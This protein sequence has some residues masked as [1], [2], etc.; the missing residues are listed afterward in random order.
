MWD[1]GVEDKWENEIREAVNLA[2]KSDV[3]VVVAGINEGE[4]QDRAYLSLPGHQEE[5][6]E[7]IAATGKPIVV[8]LVGGSAITMTKWINKV[9]AIVDVWYPGDEG[10]NAVADVLFGD[11]NPAPY[12]RSTI[13][14]VLQS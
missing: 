8:V 13:A 12:P 6:I 7:Q 1:V 2:K 14:I 10:G 4:F 11:Y 3:A 9:P 5:L